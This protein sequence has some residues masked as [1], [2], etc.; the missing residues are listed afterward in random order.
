MDGPSSI[1]PIAPS[2]PAEGIYV[3]IRPAVEFLIYAILA[4]TM[5]R[6][7]WLTWPDAFIDFSR[8]IY[9]PWRVSCGDVLY[10]DLAYYFGPVS[11]Y[12]NAALFA[13]LGHPSIHAFFA[14]DFAFWLATLL[15]LRAILRRIAP[16]PVTTLAV[17]SFIV[18]FSFNRFIFGGNFNYLSPYSH[19]LTRGFLFALLALL[20][21]DSALRSLPEAS[22][23]PLIPFRFLLPGVFWALVLFSKPEVAL[24]STA[25]LVFLFA[26]HAFCRCALLLR[27]L[28]AFAFAAAAVV[29]IAIVPFAM[30]VHS[31]A[32]ACHHVLFKIYLDCFNPDLVSLPFFKKVTGTD[33]PLIRTAWLL[34]GVLSASTPFLVAR[35]LLPR[36][37]FLP[38]RHIAMGLLAVGA[39]ALGFFAFGPLNGALA[40]APLAWLAVSLVPARRGIPALVPL[41]GA[42]DTRLAASFA[43]LAA[44]LVSKMFFNASITFYGFVLAL[45]A[46]CCALLLAFRHP[47]PN[48]RAAIAAALLLGF[49]AAA[50]RLQASVVWQWDISY[51]VH[52][53]TCLAP[54]YQANGFNATLD[55]I[56]THTPPDST[57][58]V[59]PEGA[60]LNVLSGRP[61]PTPYVSIPNTDYPR[62]DDADLLAAYS[63]TPPDTLVLVKRFGEPEFGRDYAQ[64]LLSLLNP[65]YSPAFAF[66]I[67]TASGP[68]TFI[69][70]ATRIPRQ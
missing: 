41:A 49:V 39:A 32:T 46:F 19:E 30:A 29:A 7:T 31:L 25:S 2:R 36:I 17:S 50:L 42:A 4:A 37:R 70:V 57:L 59:L 38:S 56:R 16:P 43:L 11:V 9:L 45:P 40:I 14:L 22:S 64:P 61:N 15:A 1:P 52:D 8:E 34:L 10:R 3:R 35:I 60:V 54:R 65:L 23:S 67:P 28:L 18:L 68:D 55:W 44:I 62:Y 48:Y 24:A 5:L 20:S 53:S 6:V 63:N 21:M 47:C 51:P 26:L 58:A 12:L 27:P 69:L 13:I 33:A 66:A